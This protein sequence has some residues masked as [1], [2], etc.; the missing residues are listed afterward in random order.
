LLR[1]ETVYAVCCVTLRAAFPNTT[2]R[3]FNANKLTRMLGHNSQKMALIFPPNV[4]AKK[5]KKSKTL[6]MG[7]I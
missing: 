6:A 2:Y 4:T 3:P 7:L 1:E 5:K